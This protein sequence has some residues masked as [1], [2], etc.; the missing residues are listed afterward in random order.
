MR[1]VIVGPGAMGLFFGVRLAVAGEEVV[2]YHPDPARVELLGCGVTLRDA[3]GERR[4]AVPATADPAVVGSADLVLFLVK[5]QNTAAA[6]G[7]I[8]PFLGLRT[9][10]LTLQ[11]GLGSLEYLRAVFGDGR[12]LGGVTSQGAT[13]LAPD[14]VF[15]AGVGPTLVGIPAGQD[16]AT[17]VLVE[18]LN[19]AGLEAA[20]VQDLE[21]ARWDKLLVS[22]GIN[23]LT[24]LSGI[25]NGAVAGLPAA[26]EILRVAVAEAERVAR[27]LGV[28]IAPEPAQR[29]LAV[30]RRTA[31]NRSSML[32]DLSRGRPTEV[33]AINGA[34][35][36]LGRET[37]I[38]TPANLVLC[39]LVRL[40]EADLGKPGTESLT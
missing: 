28:Q 7:A 14:T 13:L 12:V 39:N 19:G 2:L 26:E 6:A 10:L 30:A 25:P 32:Q 29:A 23:A 22:V 5:S 35:V 33:E 20:T 17:A 8:G 24:G 27:A 3:A 34:I 9:V 37:G 40:R 18:M 15:H 1:M 21:A 31:A 38:A 4:V 16:E 11:N 36:R